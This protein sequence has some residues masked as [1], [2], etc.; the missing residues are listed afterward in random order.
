MLID[1][2]YNAAPQSMRVMIKNAY[3]LRDALYADHELRLC[4]GE[5]REL[6]GYRED[7]HRK[8]MYD[9]GNYDRLYLLGQSMHEF[10]LD[11]LQKIGTDQQKYKVFSDSKALGTSVLEDLQKTEKNVLIL[12]KG[13]QNTIFLEDAVK[14]LLADASQAAQ[15]CRQGSWWENKKRILMSLVLV[16]T[17]MLMSGCSLSK[18]D[19]QQQAQIS[20]AEM[21]GTVSSGAMKGCF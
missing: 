16:C 10:A 6:G 14:L 12:F 13:S 9:L 20:G 18:S 8:L 3:E 4:L 2:S 7:E 21:S 17:G 19:M 1:S 15:L 11:E 5:M